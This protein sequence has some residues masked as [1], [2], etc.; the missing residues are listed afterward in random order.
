MALR[1]KEVL[2]I[3]PVLQRKLPACEQLWDVAINRNIKNT[4]SRLSL[5]VPSLAKKERTVLTLP[6]KRLEKEAQKKGLKPFEYDEQGFPI[7]ER[8]EMVSLHTARRTFITNIYLSGKFSVEF[9][10][11]LS[12]HKKYDTFK[13][14]VRLSAEEYV[15]IA[16]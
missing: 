13:K 9:M 7:K 12:G 1:H 14:N 5:I 6:E 10:M 2:L 8:W 4:L 16:H 15:L 11:K 3:I